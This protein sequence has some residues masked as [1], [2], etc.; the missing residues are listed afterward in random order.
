M[1]DIEPEITFFRAFFYVE[2]FHKAVT[3]ACAVARDVLVH[4]KGV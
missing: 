4:M 2:G 1:N 3:G